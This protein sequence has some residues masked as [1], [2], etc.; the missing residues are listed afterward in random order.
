MSNKFTSVLRK[1]RQEDHKFGASLGFVSNKIESSDLEP[2]VHGFEAYLC[3][4]L[5]INL[6]ATVYNL[7]VP[8]LP[9][10]LHGVRH[11]SVAEP[12]PSKHK[13]PGPVP[14]IKRRRG[15][16]NKMQGK[17]NGSYYKGLIEKVFI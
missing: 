4:L 6:E 17:G 8:R 16:G 14:S 10:V 12:L 7:S 13:S 3:H 9:D 11:S 2:G 1:L 15:R 5:A